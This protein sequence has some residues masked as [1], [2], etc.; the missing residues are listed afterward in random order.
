[1][2]SL[3]LSRKPSHI[4]EWAWGDLTSKNVCVISKVH[5]FDFLVSCLYTFNP[6]LLPLKCV[7]D[8]LCCNKKQKHGELAVLQ[9]YLHDEGKRV[10]EETIY[11]F[12]FSLNIVLHDS[13]Q[14]D[15]MV[16]EI[17]ESKQK[18]PGDYVKNFSRVLLCGLQT[19]IVS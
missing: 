10:G 7:T 17:D 16:M 3:F 14:A 2:K 4:S 11:F 1:M 12:I 18:V 6:L 13:Y 8:S 5:Y 9:D 19:S 15:E